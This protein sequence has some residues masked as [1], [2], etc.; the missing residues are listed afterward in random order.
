M[1]PFLLLAMLL[2]SAPIFGQGT[3]GARLFKSGPIQVTADGRFVWA[4]NPDND[5]VSRLE[6][7]TD[8]LHEFKLPGA[9]KHHP[10]GLSVREDGA[11]IW[12][13]CHDS[14]T[15]FALNPAGE[16]IAT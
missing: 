2:L 9:Q 5:S 15:L 6:T 12:V 3:N 14:D 16:I 13:A 11:E 1:K 8:D 7:A 10:K 4:V